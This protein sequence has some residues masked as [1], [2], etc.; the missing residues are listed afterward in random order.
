VRSWALVVFLTLLTVI[1]VGLFAPLLSVHADNLI[2]DPSFELTKQ[3]DRFGGVFAKWEGWKYEGNCSFEVGEVAHSGKTSGLMVCST[4]GKIRLAQN[5]DLEPGR[6]RITAYIRGLDLGEGAWNTSTEFM[7]AGKYMSLKR[8]GTFGWTRLVYVADLR[9]KMRTGP[10]FGLWAPGYFWIDDVSLER[11]GTDVPLT[12]TPVLGHEEAPIAAP[13]PLGAGAIRCPRCGYRNMPGW[14]KC[15]ACGSPL[16]VTSAAVAGPPVKSIASFETGNPFE[17]GSVVAEHATDGAHALRFDRGFVRMNGPQNWDGYDYLKVDT[18]LEGSQPAPVIVEIHDTATDGYWTRVNYNSVVPPGPSTLILPLRQLYVGEKSRPGRPLILGGVTV[19]AF[20]LDGPSQPLFLD[21]LRLE[22]DTAARDVFFDGLYAFDFGTGSSP[23]MEGFTPVTPATLYSP[24][25]G[26]GLKNAKVWRALDALQPDPLYQDFLCIESGGLAVDVPNGRYRVFVNIDS[27]SGYWGE[28]QAYRQRVIRAEGKVVYSERM[29]FKAFQKKYFRFWDTEDLPSDNTFDKYQQAHFSEKTFDVSV[30]H[31]QLFLEFE[32]ENWANSVSAVIVYPLEKA[33]QGDRFLRYVREKRRFYFDNA[34]KRV[35]HS[36]AGDPLRPTPEDSRR[37]YVAFVRD[38]MKDVYYNDTPA[39]G[40]TAAPLEADGFAG[41]VVPVSLAILPLK[42]LGAGTVTVGALAGPGGSI[43]ATAIDVG[44]V[45]Y[46]L[47]RVASDGSI[48]TITPRLII[49][50]DSVSLPKGIAR[51]FWFTLHVPAGMAPG[52]YT[53]QVSFTPQQG[54]RMATPLRFIVRKG[55]LDAANIP[56]GPFGGRMGTA[57]LPDDPATKA[58]DAD[59]TEKSLVMLRA[60]GF[61]MFTGVPYVVYRGFKDGN[62]VLDFTAADLQ[63]KDA[64]SYGFRAVN[65]YGAGLIGLDAYNRD[66]A[67]MKEAGFNDYSA[68]LKAI[69]SAIDRHARDKEW[70]PVY[71]NI[72]DEPLGE[73]LQRS[74]ENARDYRS[75]F[76][77]GPPLFTA[78]TSFERDGPQFELAKTVHVAALNLHN[79]A[80][81]RKLLAA[82]GSWGYYNNASRWTFGV[83]L[84]KIASEFGARFRVAWHWNLVAGDPYY[85]LDCREDDYAW[86]NTNALG[87][88]VP[89]VEFIRIA[90][91]L[92]D[93]RHLLTLAR[94]AKAKSGTPA[95]EEAEALIQNRM[96]VIHLGQFDHDKLFGI[97]DWAVY[98]RRLADALERLQ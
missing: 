39:R 17:G 15:Y 16:K 32:G 90:A 63:I 77:Q 82:G 95:A 29:D 20:V 37:G 62:P 28:Y 9:E 38:F 50:R 76:P 31:G 2:A 12:D 85:P 34:F 59:V 44:Y 21:N 87:E 86:A 5:Q 4:A 64:R 8:N 66:L 53:G 11:V 54:E 46:R 30:A 89:S 71:W 72:G 80:G 10:S 3:H 1:A 57:W 36:P 84:Y 25:R 56:V 13:A 26:Y 58:F 60:Y 40:E 92:D 18:W 43:P 45:S 75:A 22:R 24:A 52:V 49:P 42:D 96:A 81:I 79:E 67:R 88:M 97:D 61:N 98:R 78:A 69:Y 70:L 35:L 91:G 27:P 55:V 33:A 47:A 6:Y 83:Y 51:R 7:F 14:E 68:F 23:V 65:S 93:Y 41:Q 48:Y 94:L 73:G 74:L 19:L